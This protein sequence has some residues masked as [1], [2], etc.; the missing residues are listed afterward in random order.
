MER[1]RIAVTWLLDFIFRVER[2]VIP[3]AA[4]VPVVAAGIWFPLRESE[5]LVAFFRENT[6]SEG[7]TFLLAAIIPLL[8]FVL[9]RLLNDRGSPARAADLDLPPLFRS[10]PRSKYLLLF[11]HGWRGDSESTWRCFP[12]LIVQDNRFDQFDVASIDYPS[13][14][15]RRS[16]DLPALVSWLLDRMRRERFFTKY[17]AIAVIAH[18]MGG[19]VARELYVQSK[20][21]DDVARIVVI[22]AIGTP[23]RGADLAKLASVL[24]IGSR[25]VRDARPGSS[26]L[27]ALKTHWNAVAIRPVTHGISSPQDDVVHEDSAHFLCDRMF[28]YPRWG[29]RDLA[30]PASHAD[31]RYSKPA[32]IVLDAVNSVH[33]GRLTAPDGG[34]ATTEMNRSA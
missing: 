17:Q 28:S 21:S 19:L 29:H 10:D 14:M 9:M 5:A 4:L 16:L 8:A 2:W 7:F 27:D 23:H 1:V 13:F 6:F 3:A 20:L 22:V 33:W 12:E 18:S 32:A 31:D 30:K 34:L 26:F 11:I 15:F 24:G 25:L